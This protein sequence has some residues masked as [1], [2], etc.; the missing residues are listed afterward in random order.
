MDQ[1]TINIDPGPFRRRR[2]ATALWIILLTISILLIVFGGCVLMSPFFMGT[3]LSNTVGGNDNILGLN[4]PG[5]TG[6]LAMMIGLVLAWIAHK[7]MARH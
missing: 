3:G 4:Y 5:E 6:Y 1:S 7:K 2:T